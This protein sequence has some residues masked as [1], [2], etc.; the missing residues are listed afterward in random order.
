[1][2]TFKLNIITQKIEE[3]EVEGLLGMQKEVGGYLVTATYLKSNDVVIV[4]EKGLLGI[5]EGAF[6]IKDA[7][8][9]FVG[10]GLVFGIDKEGEFTEPKTTIEELK[11]VVTFLNP[12]EL[13]L[14]AKYGS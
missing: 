8:Q 2:K 1:M 10:N 14:K 5:I 13:K 3:I 12:M 4:N 9:P 7:H 11:A 6:E